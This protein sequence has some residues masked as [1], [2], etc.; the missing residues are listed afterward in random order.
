MEK[1]YIASFKTSLW[2]FES[3]SANRATAVDM[4]ADQ[5]VK[6]SK[7]YEGLDHVGAGWVRA[8]CHIKAL[9]LETVYLNERFRIDNKNLEKECI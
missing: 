4:L 8:Y 7:A 9:E 2:S 3:I 1:V 6:I 5:V